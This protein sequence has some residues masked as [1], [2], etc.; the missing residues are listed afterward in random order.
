M[1]R[2]TFT[3]ALVATIAAVFIAQVDC[4][5]FAA[6][7]TGK[8]TIRVLSDPEDALNVRVYNYKTQSYENT[9]TWSGIGDQSAWKLADQCLEITH[10]SVGFLWGIQ[11][12]TDNKNNSLPYAKSYTGDMNL[13]GL[14]GQITTQQALPIAWIAYA[15]WSPG[16][17][18]PDEPVERPYGMG[19]AGGRWHW[20]KDVNAP[21]NKDTKD[22]DE[23]F[24]NGEDYVTLWNQNGVAVSDRSRAG[25]PA[26]IYVFLAADFSTA[27]RQ[28]YKTNSLTIEHFTDSNMQA[29]PF[30]LYKD[31]APAMQMAYEHISVK[32]DKYFGGREKRLIESYSEPYP[33]GY[34]NSLEGVAFTYDNALAVCAY[35]ARPTKENLF[36]AKL[37]CKT[38]IWAQD[39]D[40]FADGRLRD[41]YDATKEFMGAAVPLTGT[42]FQS[43][44]TGNIVWVVNALMQYYKNSG[45]TDTAFLGKVLTAAVTAGEFIHS[46]FYHSSQPGYYCGYNANGTTLNRSKSTEHNIAAYVAFSHLY[47]VTGKD[48]WLQRANNAKNFVDNFAWYP[49]DKRYICGLNPDGTPNVD[50]LVADTNL[51][52]PL[53]MGISAK[54]KKNNKTINYVISHFYSKEEILGLEGI[55]FGYN[56]YNSASEPDGI[57]FEGTVQL[58]AAY[59]VAGYYGYTDNSERYL[60][61]IKR[62]Q[63]DAP[64]ADYKSIVASTRTAGEGGLTTGLGWSYYASPHIAP[65]A[66]FAAC[67]MNYN[68]LWGTSLDNAVPSPGDNASFTPD[69]DSLIDNSDYLE[70]HYT[71]SGWL[72][73]KPGVVFVDGRCTDNPYSGDTCFKIHW[74]GEAGAEYKWAGIVWQEPENEWHGGIGKGHDLRGADYLTFWARTDDFS[75]VTGK[76]LQIKV[77]FGYDNDSCGETIPLWRQPLTTEWQFYMIPVLDRDMSH[78]SNG[79][80]IIFNDTHTPWDDNKCNIYIDDIEY[81]KF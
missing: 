50:A 15:D 63:Y 53:A 69:A 34:D 17:L 4:S 12:Y 8:G 22:V 20:L 3:G 37:L 6:E 38:L 42:F 61:S 35:L 16:S 54:N 44:S 55:D 80:S 77:Y 41:A 64:N 45:D 43:S 70:N 40:T 58:A 25:N 71:P 56:V 57:W 1:R 47:D 51:L 76:D 46:N 5:V 67:K 28:F 14:V 33:W 7:S 30:C 29:F 24:H 48:K 75:M 18:I 10:A 68:L 23:S 66:W 2:L 39:N 19:F 60:E 62:A 73:Y 21:D 52:A 72:N 11:M 59:K 74:T 32:M 36:R 13:A 65:T 79:F 26:K 31:G 78:V 81:G 27:T 49:G 9:V